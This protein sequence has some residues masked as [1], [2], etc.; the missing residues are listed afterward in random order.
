MIHIYALGHLLLHKILK[1][2]LKMSK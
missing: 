1:K 2:H